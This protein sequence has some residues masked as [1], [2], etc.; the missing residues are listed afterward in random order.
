M[1]DD[2][3]YI[4]GRLVM[5]SKQ[6]LVDR[7]RALEVERD[8]LK[9]ALERLATLSSHYARLL[10]MHD[11]GNRQEFKGADEWLARLRIFAADTPSPQS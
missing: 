7:I 3:A 1:S 6:D 5:D 2:R 4:D 11:G 8:E 9:E 10:N